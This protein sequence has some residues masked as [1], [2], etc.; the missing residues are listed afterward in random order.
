MTVTTEEQLEKLKAIGGIC[1]LA[2]D[3]MADA[4]RPGM[5]TLELDAVGVKVLDEHG[6]QSAPIVTYVIRAPPASRSTRRSRTASRA[7][8]SSRRAIS[9]TSTYRR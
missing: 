9:S 1:A 8:A 3:R 7:T 6:A 4:L 5:T 2:R